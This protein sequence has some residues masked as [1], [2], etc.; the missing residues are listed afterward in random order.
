MA[1][2]E[3]QESGNKCWGGTPRRGGGVSGRSPKEWEEDTRSGC[4][5]GQVVAKNGGWPGGG[6][7]TLWT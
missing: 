4:T 6:A 7:K 5:G 1:A 2:K 3:L